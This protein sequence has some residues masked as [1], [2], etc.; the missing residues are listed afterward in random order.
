MSLLMFYVFFWL[1][2]VTSATPRFSLL[3]LYDIL[4]LKTIPINSQAVLIV[5]YRLQVIIASL[6]IKEQ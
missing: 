6:G 4:L 1:Q 5:S 2:H 3:L